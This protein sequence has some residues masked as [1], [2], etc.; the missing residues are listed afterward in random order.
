MSEE[1]REEEIAP[2]MNP[3]ERPDL[4]DYKSKDKVTQSSTGKKLILLRLPLFRHQK[5]MCKQKQN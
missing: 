5:E 3:E 1:K 4:Q 2:S